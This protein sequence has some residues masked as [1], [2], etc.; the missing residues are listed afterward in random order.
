MKLR[1]SNVI[2]FGSINWVVKCQMYVSFCYV[3]RQRC[4]KNRE[5][6][7][8]G[9]CFFIGYMYL[10]LDGRD[11][12]SLPKILTHC[13]LL[14]ENQFYFNQWCNTSATPDALLIDLWHNVGKCYSGVDVVAPY[15]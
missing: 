1:M 8:C 11:C 4:R 7:P 12:H 2:P 9:P 13:L 5:A 6:G 10:E 14:Q 15:D 3:L